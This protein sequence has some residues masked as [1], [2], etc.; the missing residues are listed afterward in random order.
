[1]ED[2]ILID[3]DLVQFTPS[4]GGATVVV[5]SGAITA[6]QVFPPAADAFVVQGKRPCLE[7]D[8]RS[9]QIRCTYI[10]PQ[11]SIPG[12]GTVK[13]DKLSPDQIAKNTRIGGKR[14]LLKGSTFTARFEVQM[15][16]KQPPPGPGAPIPDPTPIY[17]GG[18]G[19]FVS[20]NVTRKGS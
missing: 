6:G 11:Y 7:G 4:F 10:T 13:I 18:Q 8:E 9:V 3:G 16:A 19:R 17:S 5:G 14:V 15:P 1:M 20:T 12:I 2:F